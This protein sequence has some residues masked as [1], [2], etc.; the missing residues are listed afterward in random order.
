MVCMR[1]NDL[2]LVIFHDLSYKSHT[3]V[4]VPCIYAVYRTPPRIPL[5]KRYTDEEP[6]P[7]SCTSAF[8]SSALHFTS[9]FNLM[10]SQSS[11]TSHLEMLFLDTLPCQSSHL[12]VALRLR[13]TGGAA[14]RSSCSPQ[15]SVFNTAP[16]QWETT[17]LF[18]YVTCF[19][20]RGL[21]SGLLPL[22]ADKLHQV[23]STSNFA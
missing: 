10:V 23:C 4:T 18:C 20:P 5:V 12:S 9:I 19:H 14:S 21:C 8:F 11:V 2:D 22:E 13:P 17:P 3:V 16:K 15:L 6:D 7:L 1:I